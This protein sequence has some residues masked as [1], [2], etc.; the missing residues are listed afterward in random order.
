MLGERY[1]NLVPG[2]NTNAALPDGAMFEAQSQQV[3]ADQVL[4]ALDV[5]T[6]ARLSSMISGSAGVN[7]FGAAGFGAT[8]LVARG[9]W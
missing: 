9:L 2:P 3:E 7:V 5:P 6:R 8:W 4:A 1:V